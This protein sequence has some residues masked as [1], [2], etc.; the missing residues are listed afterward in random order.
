[1]KI[2]ATCGDGHFLKADHFGSALSKGENGGNA[3]TAAPDN[4]HF[5]FSVS[6][7]ISAS[8]GS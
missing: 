3:S 2:G 8:F 1:M 5:L 6:V 4:N 7:N